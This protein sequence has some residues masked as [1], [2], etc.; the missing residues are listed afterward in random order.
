MAHMAILDKCIAAMS[1]TTEQQV[2]VGCAAMTLFAGVAHL[3]QGLLA[4]S[5]C[6]ATLNLAPWFMACAGLWMIGSGALFLHDELLGFP[7]MAASMGGAAATAA[8]SPA[9]PGALFSSAT[10]AAIAYVAYTTK[11]LPLTE[12]WYIGLSAGMWVFGIFGRVLLGGST[13]DEKKAV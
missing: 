4:P 10:L 2:S 6:K 12:T 1:G 8:L 3:A 5:T 13:D 11:S 7:F 9:K